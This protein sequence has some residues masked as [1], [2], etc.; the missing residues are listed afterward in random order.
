MSAITNV[1]RWI[2]ERMR[3][4]EQQY[5]QLEAYLADSAS[6]ENQE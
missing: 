6:K 3:F 2:A 4:W 5:D 1:E